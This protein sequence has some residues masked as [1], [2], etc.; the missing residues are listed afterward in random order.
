MWTIYVCNYV[1][2]KEHWELTA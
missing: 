1:K 2:N